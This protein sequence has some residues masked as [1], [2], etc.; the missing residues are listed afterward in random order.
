[1]KIL[2][3]IMAMLA[4]TACGNDRSYHINQEKRV[5]LFQQCLKTLPAGPIATHYNDWSEVVDACEGFATRAS[6][7]C[8]GKDC[9]PKE[10]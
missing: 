4:L 3:L 2:L 1:M 9:P 5:V 8:V 7:Y 10:P 6:Y